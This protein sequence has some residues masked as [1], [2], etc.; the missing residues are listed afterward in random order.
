MLSRHLA[1]VFARSVAA[2]TKSFTSVTNW[3]IEDRCQFL[4]AN[5]IIRESSDNTWEKSGD[6]LSVAS[7][8]ANT[9]TDLKPF[10]LA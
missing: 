7:D 5:C 9:V 1:T 2:A 10:Q 6:Y 4:L 8:R 3:V